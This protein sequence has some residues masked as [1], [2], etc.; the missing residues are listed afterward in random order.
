MNEKRKIPYLN[1]ELSWIDFNSRVLEEAWKKENPLM[2]RLRFL[3]ITG[4]NLDEFFMVRVAGVKE[5]KDLQNRAEDPSGLT[6][7]ELYPILTQKIH[8]FCERQYACFGRSVLPALRKEGI[9]FLSPEELSEGQ[10][11]FVSGYFEKI[12]FPVLTPM[13]VDSS[14]PFPMLSSRSLNVAVKLKGRKSPRF[15]V[16]QVPGILPRFL[17]VPAASGSRFV[18]LEDVLAWKLGELFEPEDIRSSCAFRITRDSDLE[19]DED[20]GD[21]LTEVERS[22]RQRRR[23]K[24]VRLEISRD[25]DREAMTFLK[26]ML[27][28]QEEEIYRVPGPPD[29]S[30]CSRFSALPQFASL[31]FPPEAPVFPPADFRGCADVFG[32][33]RER[34]RMV[35]HPYE[36]FETV[37]GFVKAAAED[38][39][40]LAIKQTLY[41]VGGRSPIVS[42]LIRA[43]ENG[44]Q[45]TVLLELKARFDEENN[46]QWAKKLEEA[47]CHV[48]YGLEGLK[49]HCKIL[50][51]VRRDEDGIRRYVHMGTGNY[52]E[53]TA[54]VY[55][56]IG[57]FTCREPYGTDASSLFNFLTGYSRPPEY[58][59]FVAAPEGMREF[60]LR[61]I[62][63]ETENAGNGLPSGIV[64]KLNSLTDPAVIEVLYRASRAGVPVRLIV[65]GIC[66]LIPGVPGHSE[67]ITVRSVV[68]RFLEHSRIYEFTDG[69]DPK[70]FLGSA[71]WMQRNFDTRV[72]LAFPVEDERLR[73]R[74]LQILELMLQDNRNARILHPDTVYTR[75]DR[76][77]KKPLDCQKE[78][79]RLARESANG[80]GKKERPGP[81]RAISGPE[82]P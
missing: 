68:G 30:F 31:C 27:E 6:P 43:A 42:S 70:V 9:A 50:L 10:K 59:R 5:R 49:T 16:V 25:C 76:R 24:P 8:A 32:A 66:C 73:R 78:F 4:S 23:G 36:S 69:G 77:G 56:D 80:A 11:R 39:N 21:F 72:E 48:I 1:R 14:R 38:R 22:V 37:I 58:N 75:A 74:V 28:L 40:V 55:T 65:R 61:R 29:L 51:V 81:Y 45:V 26:D 3:G 46:I 34:D 41:R 12:L 47:G 54:R 35:H 53:T 67:T 44:K 57:I 71:D 18:L 2:E 52:N 62:E 79:F 19:I 13:A 20:T 82:E 33:I 63:R 60:F 15:A 64:A 17:S 7:S